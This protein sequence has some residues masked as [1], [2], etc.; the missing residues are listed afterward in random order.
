MKL[1]YSRQ[2]GQNSRDRTRPTAFA[3]VLP[4]LAAL[5]L[6]TKARAQECDFSID[7]NI[8]TVADLVMTHADHSMD[9][10]TTYTRRTHSGEEIEDGKDYH[11]VHIKAVDIGGTKYYVLFFD[12]ASSEGKIDKSDSLVILTANPDPLGK[13][14]LDNET[15]LRIINLRNSGISSGGSNFA[16]MNVRGPGPGAKP[17]STK[18]IV[19]NEGLGDNADRCLEEEQAPGM[20]S[21][22]GCMGYFSSDYNYN[23]VDKDSYT[24]LIKRIGQA[25]V[26][27]VKAAAAAPASQ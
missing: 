25:L 2:I 17:T 27:Q 23:P 21:R 18:T 10:T 22:D 11:K 20:F 15:A 14:V 16:I 24:R 6:P 7:C 19:T 26:E 8:W 5:V 4:L 3:A 9:I 12:H 1:N 13:G